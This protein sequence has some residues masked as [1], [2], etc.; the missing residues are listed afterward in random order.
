MA[1]VATGALFAKLTLR[2]RRAIALMALASIVVAALVTFGLWIG[3]FERRSAWIARDVTPPC[4]GVGSHTVVER[5]ADPPFGGT[6]M[7]CP[8]QPATDW[9][10][11]FPGM[12]DLEAARY[13]HVGGQSVTVMVAH[14]PRKVVDGELISYVNRSVD[15]TR[16]HLVGAEYLRMTDLG[17]V[18]FERFESAN[19]RDTLHVLS[20]FMVG[21]EVL[22]SRYAVKAVSTLRRII[23]P[24][25]PAAQVFVATTGDGSGASRDERAVEFL[26]SHL[27]KTVA[28]M[29]AAGVDCR[30]G[31]N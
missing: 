9:R 2:S 22:S 18:R 25:L 26:A 31:W 11:F 16:W 30:A 20:V 13:T 28:C 10:P 24:C 6:G 19:C 23:D 8:D 15:E 27:G 3:R 5:R 29:N 7:V 12:P 17:P 4:D 1:C 21:E 14:Y